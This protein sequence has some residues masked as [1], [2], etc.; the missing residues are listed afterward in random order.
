[1]KNYKFNKKVLRLKLVKI[2]TSQEIKNFLEKLEE[3]TVNLNFFKGLL[4]IN[5]KEFYLGSSSAIKKILE[6]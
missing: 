4:E 3:P 6:L 2:N 5:N 1:M